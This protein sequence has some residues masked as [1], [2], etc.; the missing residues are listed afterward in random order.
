MQADGETS[1]WALGLQ[2]APEYREPVHL[3]VKGTIPPWLA[4]SLYRTGPGTYDI[5]YKD[6]GAYHA[7]H[8]FDAIGMN[9]RFEIK[10]GGE[11]WYRSRKAA[12]LESEFD[13]P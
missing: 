11:V 4:G 6:G 7:Q 5:P 9:H 10:E 13:R 12:E 2:N 3:K 1:I 8:W